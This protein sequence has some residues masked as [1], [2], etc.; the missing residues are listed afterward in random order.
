MAGFSQWSSL[1]DKFQ[2]HIANFL[3]ESAEQIVYSAFDFYAN[4]YPNWSD[5]DNVGKIRDTFKNNGFHWLQ[6]T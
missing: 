4:G 1:G 2:K 5:A 6:G 3:F